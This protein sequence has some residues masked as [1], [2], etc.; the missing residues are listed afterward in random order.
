MKRSLFVILTVCIL[1]LTSCARDPYKTEFNSSDVAALVVG[2][3]GERC[4]LY[5]GYG[6]ET[7]TLDSELIKKLYGSSDAAKYCI[8]YAVFISRSSEIWEA[9]FFRVRSLYD[10]KKVEKMLRKRAEMIDREEIHD[11]LGEKRECAIVRRKNMVCLFITEDNAGYKRA[12][13]KI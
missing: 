5:V 6:Y 13:D 12:L 7:D 1:V 2:D 8:D 3:K 11:Y 9:H 4:D 10:I